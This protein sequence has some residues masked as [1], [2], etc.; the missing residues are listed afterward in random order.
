VGEKERG[1]TGR[2]E[3]NNERKTGMK[4]KP[5]PFPVP[6]K[7][8]ATPGC[9]ISL[10]LYPTLF[11]KC[12]FSQTPAGFHPQFIDAIKWV[13]YMRDVPQNQEPPLVFYTPINA[14]FLGFNLTRS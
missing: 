6:R 5:S 12:Y 2:K 13:V 3:L 4:S 10:F 11:A 14:L 8:R 1:E 7:F 9:C